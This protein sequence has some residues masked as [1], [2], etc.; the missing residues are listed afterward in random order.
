MSPYNRLCEILHK[1]FGLTPEQVL[2]QDKAGKLISS[3]CIGDNKFHTIEINKFKDNK[4]SLYNRSGYK[5][6]D[7]LLKCKNQR[8]GIIV[9][10][11]AEL[12]DK[13]IYDLSTK[14]TALAIQAIAFPNDIPLR[15]KI[16]K[17]AT[18]KNLIHV[19]W[20]V[21]VKSLRDIKKIVPIDKMKYRLKVIIIGTVEKWNNLGYSYTEQVRF[22][23]RYLYKS[24]L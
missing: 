21:W 20:I 12:G 23:T 5:V 3:I 24:A 1:D 22:F 4:D 9:S 6:S 13:S 16:E 11:L 14:E 10:V 15:G 2:E 8:G 7:K 18:L 17:A 19:H